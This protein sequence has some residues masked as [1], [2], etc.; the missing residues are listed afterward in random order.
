MGAMNDFL[1]EPLFQPTGTD[2]IDHAFTAAV[3]DDME[4][5]ERTR[6]S[7]EFAA[8]KSVVKT[9]T[10][11][12][13]SDVEDRHISNFNFGGGPISFREFIEQYIE[14]VQSLSEYRSFIVGL[15]SDKAGCGI[16]PLLDGSPA[17][18]LFIYVVDEDPL[19]VPRSLIEG[20]L[21]RKNREVKIKYCGESEP[22]KTGL[23]FDSYIV[24]IDG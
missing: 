14:M 8:P 15:P 3:L 5:E 13:N 11:S 24:T 2:W 19:D 4:R 9:P 20:L 21:A 18:T 16:T 1:G 7:F 23:Y 10:E 22:D 12:D 6:R 17:D